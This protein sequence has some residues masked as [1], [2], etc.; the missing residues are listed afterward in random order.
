MPGSRKE[1]GKETSPLSIPWGREGSSSG[2]PR[3]LRAKG[4]HL[5]HAQSGSSQH[6][7]VPTAPFLP[8]AKA[9]CRSPE[10]HDPREQ[11]QRR[12]SFE[13]TAS[14]SQRAGGA[15]AAPRAKQTEQSSSTGHP[16][17]R[18]GRAGSQGFPPHPGFT[19]GPFVNTS[20]YSQPSRV[21]HSKGFPMAEHSIACCP[22]KQT[23]FNA[24][25]LQT[26]PG[27][28]QCP[29]RNVRV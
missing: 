1:Q 6:G 8:R 12:V 19:A 9:Q 4:W 25:T 7:L 21:E 16:G 11:Q 5:P 17:L 27:N 20:G 24:R 2:Q 26:E 28:P 10:H 13:S 18:A 3:T 14:R 22:S 29:E 15:G 23:A